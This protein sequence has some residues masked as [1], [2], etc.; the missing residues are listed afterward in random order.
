M[1]LDPAS[2]QTIKSA[3]LANPTAAGFRTAGDAA[4]LLAWLN[5]A[6]SPTVSCWRSIGPKML[7]SA[8]DP[9]EADNLSVGKTTALRL[10][11][12]YLGGIDATTTSGRKAISDLFPNASVPNTRAAALAVA[13][14][15][16][17]NAQAAFSTVDA[18]SPTP[19]AVTAKVRT[20][21]GL[22]DISDANWLIN[23]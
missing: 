17:T 15:P 2:R 11:L 21:A 20:F 13:Q 5:A 22:C 12:D 16:I 1:A 23:N 4:S 10:V 9:S 19:T 6:A 14:E 18:T 3:V 8:V 7:A